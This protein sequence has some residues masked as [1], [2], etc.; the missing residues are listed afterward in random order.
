MM[1]LL[2][3][4]SQKL[5]DLMILLIAAHFSSPYSDNRFTERLR[6]GTAE[7]LLKQPLRQGRTA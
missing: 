6:T 4:Q 2:V 5:R 7:Y 1:A 3:L